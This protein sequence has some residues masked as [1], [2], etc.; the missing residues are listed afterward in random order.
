MFFGIF[1]ASPHVFSMLSRSFITVRHN[2]WSS[3]FPFTLKVPCHGHF[4]GISS[5]LSQGMGYPFHFLRIIVITT[6]VLAHSSS[7]V[8]TSGQKMLS[9]WRSNYFHYCGSC[10]HFKHQS[11]ARFS[12]FL[13]L[14]TMKPKGNFIFLLGNITAHTAGNAFSRRLVHAQVR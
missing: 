6:P 3:L 1:S 12:S 13:F 2:D 7:F 4:G 5:L 8:M 11:D 14:S 9:I 10:C